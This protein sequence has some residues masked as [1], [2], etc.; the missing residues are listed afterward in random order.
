MAETRINEDGWEEA[1]TSNGWRPAIYHYYK[2]SDKSYEMANPPWMTWANGS[3][4]ED[5]DY[6]IKYTN[7]TKQPMC[8]TDVGLK[9][10]AG[11]S[12]GAGGFWAYG[13]WQSDDVKGVGARYQ[14]LV[15]VQQKDK[16][17]YTMVYG[18]PKEDADTA[19]G[20]AMKIPRASYNMDTPGSGPTSTATF[21]NGT[22]GYATNKYNTLRFRRFYFP[23]CP[24]ILPGRCAYIHLR[25]KQF[26]YADGEWSGHALIRFIMD[27]NEGNIP[28]VPPP[29]QNTPYVWRYQKDEKG[30]LGW[31]LVEPIFMRAK[32]G[33]WKEA[34]K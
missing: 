17:K 11:N 3:L 1:W 5:W 30:K 20:K 16:S 10:V 33:K 15:N 26:D 23:E 29:A 6:C 25:I 22:G 2:N 18:T 24:T 13:S 19:D 8:I 4:W 9:T 7:I 28:I 21:G 31:H 12:E 27:P 32:D 14:V 34:K